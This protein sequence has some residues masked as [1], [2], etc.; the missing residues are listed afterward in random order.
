[1]EAPLSGQSAA[2]SVG[3]TLFVLV[4]AGMCVRDCVVGDG[5]LRWVTVAN[6]SAHVAMGLDMVAMVW[7]SRPGDRWS[8]QMTVFTLACGWF[9]VQAAGVSLGTAVMRP[10]LSGVGRRRC[11]SD[12]ETVAWPKRG[13]HLH[14]AALMATMVWMLAPGTRSEPSMTGMAMVAPTLGTG[15]R[16]AAAVMAGYCLLAAPVW[17]VIHVR[18]RTH[19]ISHRGGTLAHALMAGAMGVMLLGMR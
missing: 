16:Y 19:P 6:N 7:L 5:R 18:R 3:L 14:H 17:V 13:Q 1:L 11:D 4:A 2:G 8:L 10:A 9:L 15:A 12:A